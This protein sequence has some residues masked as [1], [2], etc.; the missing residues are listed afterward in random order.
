[1]PLNGGEGVL[2][3][4]SVPEAGLGLRADEAV[5][6]DVWAGVGMGMGNESGFDFGFGFGG[7]GGVASAAAS[8]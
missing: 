6:D 1:M 7:F 5:E 8:S 4:G 2:E 3:G